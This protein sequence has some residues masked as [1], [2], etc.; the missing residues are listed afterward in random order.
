MNGGDRTL[1]AIARCALQATVATHAWV[2]HRRAEGLVA[3]AA[4][5]PRA[6]E[7]LGRA[8]ASGNG[9][10]GYVIASGEALVLSAAGGDP[11]LAEGLP[12]E[13]GLTPISVLCVPCVADDNVLGALELVDKQDGGAFGVDDLEI[14]GMLGEVAGAALSQEALIPEVQG[15]H[16][17]GTELERLSAADPERYRSVA[18]L[19]TALLADS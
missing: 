1:N 10:A 19:L 16:E 11:R 3:V 4:T 13:L 5:G 8:P 15:P 14:C 7:A 18:S 6:G 17:L 2:L 12:A 9:S